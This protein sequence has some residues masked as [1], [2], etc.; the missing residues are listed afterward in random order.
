[1]MQLSL[2]TCFE[3]LNASTNMFDM[4]CN[5]L[6]SFNYDMANLNPSLFFII[7]QWK[8]VLHYKIS[9]YRSVFYDAIC[10]LA[11]KKI[12][13]LQ[14][15]YHIKSKS[16]FIFRQYSVKGSETNGNG[17]WYSTYYNNNNTG[18]YF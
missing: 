2:S 12:V 13:V 11:F 6:S 16:I 3:Y 4:M 10:F 1:M 7:G 14:S 17:H 9:N 18:N 8:L 5:V 15:W